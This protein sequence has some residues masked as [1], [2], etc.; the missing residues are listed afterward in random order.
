MDIT[1]SHGSY[2]LVTVALIYLI[3][4]LST[5]D[6]DYVICICPCCFVF[7]R[8]DHSASV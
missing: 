8:H 3:V 4:S 2:V 7:G 5:P 1:P 6:V